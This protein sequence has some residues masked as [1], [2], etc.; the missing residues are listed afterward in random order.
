MSFGLLHSIQFTFG[1]TAVVFVLHGKV[2]RDREQSTNAHFS[3]LSLDRST[4][5]TTTNVASVWIVNRILCCRAHTNS[6]INVSSSGSYDD[7]QLVVD[8]GSLYV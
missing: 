1:P 5:P 4:C 8:E 7:A 3:S 6:V 2:V